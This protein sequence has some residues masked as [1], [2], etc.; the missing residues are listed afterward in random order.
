[1]SA[2]SCVPLYAECRKQAASADRRHA[3]SRAATGG[4]AWS[5]CARSRLSTLIISGEPFAETPR[6]DSPGEILREDVLKPL[7]MSVNQLVK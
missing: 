3:D 1:M 2:S 7:N 4:S 6:T 5:R